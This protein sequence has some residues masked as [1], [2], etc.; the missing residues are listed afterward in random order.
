M[1]IHMIAIIYFL[2][3]LIV[4]HIRDMVDFGDLAVAFIVI[5]CAGLIMGKMNER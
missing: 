5:N 1:I 3:T 2:I 4:G